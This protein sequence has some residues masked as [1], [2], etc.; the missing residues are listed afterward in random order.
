MIA[1]MTY[2]QILWYFMIYSFAGW[3]IEV[4]FHAITLEKVVNRGFLNGPVCPVYGCGILLVLAVGN[5]AEALTGAAGELGYHTAGGNW[6]DMIFLFLGGMILAT[7]VELIAGWA[8]DVLFH[9]RWWDYSERPRNFHGY[10]CLEFSVIWGVAAVLVVN[11]IHPLVRD[12]SVAAIPEHYGWYILL[13]LYLLFAAD[14]VVSVLVVIGL[15]KRLAEIDK[16]RQS[17][18]VMSDRMSETIAGTTL[19]A[20]QKVQETEVQAALG[21]AELRD[22]MQEKI[23]EAKKTITGMR[24]EAE[25]TISGMRSDA[26]NSLADRRAEYEQRLGELRAELQQR[27]EKAGRKVAATRYFGT[28]RLLRAFPQMASRDYKEILDRLKAAADNRVEKWDFDMKVTEEETKE[29]NR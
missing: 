22:A 21:K 13:A 17:M 2:Y 8:L 16:V 27:V 12:R 28:G 14:V 23:G 20:A 10:I 11:T 24:N 9:T 29:K 26:E 25:K 15:N 7:L 18:R 1:G 6:S 3:V 4:A 19:T 5:A